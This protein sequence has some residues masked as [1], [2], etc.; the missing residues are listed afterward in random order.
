MSRITLSTWTDQH[1]RFAWIEIRI[2]GGERFARALALAHLRRRHP[3]A[4][5][6]RIAEQWHVPL[7][8]RAFKVYFE[9]D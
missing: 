2:P 5:S 4:R 6:L 9:I 1:G 8:H 7:S 3:G